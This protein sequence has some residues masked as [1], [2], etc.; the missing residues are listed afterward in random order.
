MGLVKTMKVYLDSIGCRLNQSEIEHMAGR[1]RAAG[2]EIVGTPGQADLVVVNTCTVTAKAAADSRKQI[3]H[4]WRAGAKWV[5]ATG[6][7]ATLNP[8]G[9]A[10]LPGVERVVS[11]EQKENLV[12]E[13]LGLPA[14]EF[15]LEPLARE[16]L[17]GAHQRTRAFIK[18]QDGCDNHCT[19]CITRVAR[20]PSRSRSLAEVLQD[21]RAARQGGANE[22]VLTGV[23]L[24]SWGQDFDSPRRL[25]DLMEAVLAHTDVPRL[26]ISSLEPWDLDDH[27]FGLWREERL[28]RHLHLPLQS[29][30]RSTLRRMARKTTPEEY[31]GLVAQAR[32]VS[33]QIA[34]TTDI[35][36]GFPGET[37]ADFEE[38]LAFVEKIE[39]AAGHVFTYSPR[40][41]TPAARC[42]DQVDPQRKKARNAAFRQVLAR[43]ADRYRRQFTGQTMQVL[44]E[45]C[46]SLGPD[47]WRMNGLTDNYLR[48][49]AAAAQPLWNRFS[50]V[51]LERL[52]GAGLEGV[53]V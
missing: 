28:C 31:A 25:A 2:H 49:T 1:F 46:D 51:R 18:A 44:W 33:P 34:I 11:N 41:G 29:G 13:V 22:V 36:A 8:A 9:A 5:V 7:W 53:L 48:V 20:G 23:Q 12:A 14:A 43:S 35:I 10:A 24:G 27:F 26:R 52:A 4:A 17:P 32:A 3:R 47:G 50:A 45:S 39:F 19:F 16:P 38:S 6:C 15:D 40:E 37:E 21:V 42:P 30:A